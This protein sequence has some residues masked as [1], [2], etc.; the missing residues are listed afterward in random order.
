[1]FGRIR[2][3]HW[4]SHRLRVL[5]GNRFAIRFTAG[6]SDF[7]TLL[8]LGLPLTDIAP[9]P[10]LVVVLSLALAVALLASR[11][12]ITSVSL[13]AFSVAVGGSLYFLENMSFRFDSGFMAPGVLSSIAPSAFAG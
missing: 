10:Q 7:I 3:R 8:T 2:A 4:P 13:I 5:L 9:A 6:A 12:E 11:F 1:M